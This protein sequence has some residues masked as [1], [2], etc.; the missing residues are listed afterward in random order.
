MLN[1]DISKLTPIYWDTNH[2]GFSHPL[3][4][5]GVAHVKVVCPSAPRIFK[6]TPQ[7]GGISK[8]KKRLDKD[9][10]PVFCVIN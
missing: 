10:K 5:G 8:T 3:H 9:Y 1:L 2:G 7:G 4:H 6:K